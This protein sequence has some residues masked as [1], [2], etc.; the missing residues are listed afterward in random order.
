M[1]LSQ[2]LPQRCPKLQRSLSQYLQKSLLI[3]R[4]K[5]IFSLSTG[6]I[7]RKLLL[8][9]VCVSFSVSCTESL[10]E[11]SLDD[12]PLTDLAK[13]LYPTRQRNAPATPVMKSKR[14]AA[15]KRGKFSNVD[16]SKQIL[17]VLKLK[18]VFVAVKSAET[19]SDSS[20]NEPQREKKMSAKTKKAQSKV[21]VKSLKGTQ[22]FQQ[23]GLKQYSNYSV[24]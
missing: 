17:I 19:S 22:H 15:R 4:R 1:S 8:C 11:D 14:N 18:I 7:C 10:D 3:Q 12:E 23:A 13:K 20:D 9:V 2:R 16:T 24:V 6:S 5:V 21:K